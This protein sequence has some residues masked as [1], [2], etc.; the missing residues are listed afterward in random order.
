MFV[1]E[2]HLERPNLRALFHWAQLHTV[3][4]FVGLDLLAWTSGREDVSAPAAQTRPTGGVAI[5]MT[6]A[7]FKKH[8]WA[9]EVVVE[10]HIQ[11]LRGIPRDSLTEHL[12]DAANAP[13]AV[14]EVLDLP[15][16]SRP[17][18]ACYRT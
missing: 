9:H 11:I 1:Q 6:Q 2:T 3:R 13:P 8:V 7:Y 10:R 16:C 14:R 5:F 12:A 4:V 18:P 15:G 17:G